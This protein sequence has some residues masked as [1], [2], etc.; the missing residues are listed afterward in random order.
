M[1]TS[2]D[3]TYWLAAMR[4]PHIGPAKFRRWIELF[5]DI[6][7]LFSATKETLQEAGLKPRE[8][9]AIKNPD[10]KSVEA[11]L[12]W[13]EKNHCHLI[14]LVDNKYSTLLREIHT[15][16]LV[17]YVQGD[18][19]ILNQPQL[20]IVG[21]RNPTSVGV[22]TAMQFAACLA[23]SGLIITSGL[24]GGIDAASH[25]G[26]LRANSKTIAVCGTGLNHVYP[27]SHRKLA[28]EIISHGALISE[29]PPDTLPLA[30]NFPQRNRIISGLSLGILVVEAALKSGSLITARTAIEQ[31]RDVFALPGSIH[32]PLKRGCH[33]LIRQGA[34]LVETAADI[35]EELGSLYTALTQYNEPVSSAPNQ[36]DLS[37]EHW[38]LLQQIDDD[39]TSLDVISARSGLTTSKVS[40]MLLDLELAEC[41]Q[42]VPG[43]YRRILFKTN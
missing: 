19:E 42:I 22:E 16:P 17:L 25:R 15:A 30:K 37:Q 23:K 6:K 3:I 32:S 38:K 26:A 28:Q 10:W 5:A 7:E 2:T 18:V 41:V 11:D 14:S 8:I 21:S 33:H 29:F 20:A 27:V 13:S 35:L 39:A 36:K 31:G 1:H 43:G 12:Q 9:Q 40:S 4:L 24:A 34:K